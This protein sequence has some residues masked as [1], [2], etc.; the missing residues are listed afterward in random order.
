MRKLLGFSLLLAGASATCV[1]GAVPTP[2]VDPASGS[3][4][5]T[6]IAGALLI[7]RGRRKK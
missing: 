7:I 1:A 5:L 3:A 4:A 6:L 2:E